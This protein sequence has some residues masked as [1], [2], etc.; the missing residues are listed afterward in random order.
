M[1]NMIKIL[2]MRLRETNDKLRTI[3]EQYTPPPADP[4]S[5]ITIDEDNPVFKHPADESKTPADGDGLKRFKSDEI[6][7]DLFK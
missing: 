4:G 5:V 1:V 3:V 2:V 6:L 7:E